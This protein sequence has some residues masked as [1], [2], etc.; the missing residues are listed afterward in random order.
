VSQ[1]PVDDVYID[2]TLL[3][4][5]AA[6]EVFKATNRHTGQVV[7]VKKMPVNADNEKLL[8]TE[9]DIMKSSTH[10]NIVQY[11][12]SY[13]PSPGHI[14]VVMELMDGGCLTDV[15]D[16]WDEV[17]MTEPQMS[18]CCKNTLQALDYI[19]KGHRIHRDIKSDNILLNSKGQVKV[20]D[21]GYAA[22][23]TQ[24]RQKRKTVVGTPYWMAPEL[25]R[26]NEYSVKVDIWS[27][28]IM[29]IEML[30]GQPPYMEFPPLRALF[31]IN[32]KGIPPLKSKQ[33]SPELMEFYNACLESNSDKRQ[34]AEQLLKYPFIAKACSGPELVSVIKAASDAAKNDGV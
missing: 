2:F 26:G 22:Q 19:H 16:Q 7:A 29:L 28:G 5:G 33:W 14:W 23:L 18:L 31:L 17:K 4:T 8:V 27:L 20:A 30:E 12:D 6:G 9:I 24:E 21:F 1:K 11:F 32:A 13:I 34:L 10:P 3:G 15:L 25:I